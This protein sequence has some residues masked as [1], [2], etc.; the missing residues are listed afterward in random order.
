MLNILLYFFYCGVRG[1]G[2]LGSFWNVAVAFG[3]LRLLL[4]CCGSFWNVAVA[5][6]MLR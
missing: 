5:S 6:G 4:E 2:G 1:G 3:M